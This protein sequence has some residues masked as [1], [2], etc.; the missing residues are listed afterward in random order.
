MH[1][2][3]KKKSIDLNFHFPSMLEYMRIQM[4][5]LNYAVFVD[6]IILFVLAF[7]SVFS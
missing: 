6:Q 1:N 4:H 3:T 5:W 7:Y 2:N